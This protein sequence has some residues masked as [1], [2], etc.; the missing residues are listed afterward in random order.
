M[1]GSVPGW[2]ETHRFST[3][4]FRKC[5]VVARA[6]YRQRVLK[7]PIGLTKNR[8]IFERVAVSKY[9]AHV[10]VV[11][12]G[13]SFETKFVVNVVQI[14]LDVDGVVLAEALNLAIWSNQPGPKLLYFSGLGNVSDLPDRITAA[15]SSQNANSVVIDFGLATV[16]VDARQRLVK[17]HHGGHVFVVSGHFDRGGLLYPRGRFVGKG[18]RGQQ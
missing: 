8:S 5:E 11:F 16:R 6:D 18:G 12:G 15:F 9:G 3:P 1:R 4:A 10:R 14:R 7:R 13:N 2:I 17:Q